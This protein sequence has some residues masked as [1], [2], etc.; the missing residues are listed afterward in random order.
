MPK[1]IAELTPTRVFKPQKVRFWSYLI[2]AIAAGG[3]FLLA[4][5]IPV[6]YGGL[7]NF[8]GFAVIGSLIWW[9]CHRQAS[10]KIELFEA[11]LK[12]RNLFGTRFIKWEEIEYLSYPQGNAWPQLEL[13]EA[14]PL[15]LMALQRID[16]ESSLK[17]AQEL[18]DIIRVRKAALA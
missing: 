11:G 8:F 13:K 4:I 15:S 7:S 3:A 6:F 2:G 10:V 5:I 18:E 16:G 12:V 17:L 9:L 1:S 14:D